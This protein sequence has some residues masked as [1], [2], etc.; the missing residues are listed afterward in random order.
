MWLLAPA[1]VDGGIKS[2]T[3]YRK[4][5]RAV[6]RV[7]M[8]PDASYDSFVTPKRNRNG[9]KS[10]KARRTIRKKIQRRQHVDQPQ[11]QQPEPSSFPDFD[12]TALVH[13][14]ISDMQPMTP[15][16]SSYHSEGFS[17]TLSISSRHATPALR[18]TEW[19]SPASVHGYPSPAYYPQSD[20]GF[21]S[22]FDATPNAYS[23]CG[24]YD[25]DFDNRNE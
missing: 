25:G 11:Q 22:S 17:E 21:S 6:E 19:Q 15:D 24:P 2:T 5:G 1:A 20:D 7:A 10:L 9:K 16:L 12:T 14:P 8:S 3:R 13:T 23:M 4:K 18:P